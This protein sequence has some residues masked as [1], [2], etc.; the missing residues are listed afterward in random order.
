[1]KRNFRGE[2]FSNEDLHTSQLSTPEIQQP[3][4]NELLKRQF[5]SNL[6]TYEELKDLNYNNEEFEILFRKQ[7]E[8]Y[9][10]IADYLIRNT[11]E[12]T[13]L[14]E[15]LEKEDRNNEQITSLIIAIREKLWANDIFKNTKTSFIRS[16]DD[17]K[18]YYSHNFFNAPQI[19]ERNQ[20]LVEVKK[21]YHWVPE[22]QL[23]EILENG[24]IPRFCGK[25]G[26]NFVFA[27]FD[28]NEFWAHQAS[29]INREAK[30]NMI[31]LEIDT[32]GIEAFMWASHTDIF[33]EDGEE[34][35]HLRSSRYSR[36]GLVSSKYVSLGIQISSLVLQDIKANHQEDSE[37]ES[38]YST[39]FKKKISYDPLYPETWEHSEVLLDY[40]PP[41]NIKIIRKMIVKKEI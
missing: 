27:S 19:L 16:S 18:E 25:K 5:E 38:R 31:E 34:S 2:Y 39:L 28:R 33:P 32:T 7:R 36:L 20:E 3:T 12:F 26:M 15:E 17:E 6:H 35:R 40:V 8:A 4:Q 13:R 9:K 10:N 14:Q 23:E 37:E 41:E 24:L 29:S 1:M 11:I 22:K 21:L 30:A